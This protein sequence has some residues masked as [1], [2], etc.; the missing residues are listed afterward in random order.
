MN[1]NSEQGYL[2]VCGDRANGYNFGVLTCE[3]CKAFFRRNAIREEEIK[4]PF[5][6][7]CG[8]TSASRRFCQACRLQKC[9][10]VGLLPKIWKRSLQK[11][12]SSDSEDVKYST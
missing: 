5:S 8:I 7:N 9:F 6:N 11:R 10:A 4:C 3:S 1:M 2:Q 12:C